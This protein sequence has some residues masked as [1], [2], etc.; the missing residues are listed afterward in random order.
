MPEYPP[1]IVG[2]DP[3][4]SGGI[5]AIALRPPSSVLATLAYPMPDTEAD[6][7]AILEDLR[8][9]ITM[10]YIE[11]VHA[12]PGQGVTSMFTF[13]QN[14]GFLRGLLVGLKIPFQEVTPMKWKKDL[15]LTFSKS[16]SKKDKK[17]ASKQRAQ[18]WFPHVKMTH[19]IAEAL[20]IA[21]WG[22]RQNL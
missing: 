11:A 16:D 1:L 6:T 5:A 2:I 22:R 18:Q 9:A 7:A 20:L 4:A 12:F 8:P 21:E 10:A 14:Y 13:G 17:N 15:R 3:G 19:S